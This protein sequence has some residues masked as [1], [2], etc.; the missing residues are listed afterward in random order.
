MVPGKFHGE[1]KAP[2][3]GPTKPAESAID[4]AARPCR[5]HY[6]KPGERGVVE[7]EENDGS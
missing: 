6:R 4:S 2:R 5:Y 1:R 7:E 3:L